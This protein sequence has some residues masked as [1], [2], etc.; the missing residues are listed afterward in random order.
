MKTPG[1]GCRSTT[2]VFLKCEV[3]GDENEDEMDVK[4]RDV[5][6][7]GEGIHVQ[8]EGGTKWRSEDV[9]K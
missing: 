8:G 3:R 6:G 1:L 7:K 9:E 5:R 4:D 2:F